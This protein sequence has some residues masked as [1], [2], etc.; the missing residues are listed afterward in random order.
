MKLIA[1]RNKRHFFLAPALVLFSALTATAVAGAN[2]DVPKD[3]VVFRAMSDELDRS[4]HRL[5]LDKYKSP[6]FIS[7][8]VRQTDQFGVLAS[9]GAVDAARRERKRSLSVDVR[10]GDY[11]LDSSGHGGGS[12]LPGTHFGDGRPGNPITVD[13][14]YDSI[15]HDIWLQTDSAYKRA[16]EDLE[17]KNA[18]LQENNVKD[19]PDSMSKE[20][21]VVAIQSDAKLSVDE[22]A[23]EEMVRKLSAIFRD[24]PKIQKSLVSLDENADTRWF[25]N[26]EGFC[27]R[28]PNKRCV[29]VAMAATQAEDGSSISDM[30]LFPAESDKD[31]PSYDELAGKLKALADRVTQLAAAKS[32]D[33]YRGPMILEGDAAAE[34]FSQALQPYLGHSAEPLNKSGVFA[35]MSKN[36]LAEKL[37]VRI[38]P[39]FIDVVDD[40]LT[41]KFGDTKLLSSYTIDDDGVKAQKVNLVEKGILKT[42]C[43]SRVPSREIKQSNGHARGSSGVANNIYIISDAKFTPAQMKE[44]LIAYGK[45]DGLKEVYIARRLW[46]FG[47]AALEPASFFTNLVSGFS[48]GS[49]VRVFPPVL[50]YKVSTEDGHEELVRGAQFANLTMRVLRD[51][52]CTGDTVNAF[53]QVGIGDVLSSRGTPGISTV[54]TPSILVREIEL[55]KPSK[56]SERLPI[57]PSPNFDKQ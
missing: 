41:D 37:G 30:E 19:R 14:N 29:L 54:V 18:Y 10:E 52:D 4:L 45:E 11:S 1:P 5:H 34:F 8:T 22:T 26:S 21:P 40:P 48:S 56:E 39:S 23:A 25:L 49:G 20:Q 3:D 55:A 9:F 50:L 28:T 51:I 43:M 2:V 35:S 12:F 15:R 27:N 31:L 46:H 17:A 13:D 33:Q 32:A 42:F 7:Y 36:P 38:L 44:K 57:L 16:I 53:S 47:L 24:Y 6:Y